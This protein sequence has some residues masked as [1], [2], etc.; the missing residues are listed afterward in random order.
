[1]T[2]L[3][4]AY[5]GAQ[6]HDGN[7]L[8]NAH[9]LVVNSDNS[10]RIAPAQ[11]LPDGCPVHRFDGGIITPAFVDLQVN[12]GGGVMFN[13]DPSVTT[14]Q[15]IACAHAASGTRALL[16]TLITDTPQKTRAAI[17]AVEQAIAEKVDGI[18]GIHLEGPHLSISRKGAHDP[19]LIRTMTHTDLAVICDA[20]GRLPNVMVTVAPENVSTRQIAQMTAAGVTVSLGH[21]NAD[22]AACHAAFDAGA[23]CVTHLFNAMS[24]L[25]SRAPGLVGATLSRDDI[26]AGLIA[27]AIHVHPDTIRIA[28]AAKPRSDKIFLVTDAMATA[29]SH[30]SRFTLNGRD[31]FRDNGRLTLADGTLA[32]A[33]LDMPRALSI[34]TGDVGDK[35]AKAIAR[36][37]STPA[38]VLRDPMGAGT[39]TGTSGTFLYFANGLQGGQPQQF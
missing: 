7:V 38:A 39:L 12:G 2:T 21:T 28:L 24:Q 31:V 34:M 23:R 15:T 30:I 29:G 3:Q 19:S 20:A 32:G 33:D 17:A 1:M 26:F 9:A 16:A 4:K 10:L 14:L 13:D 37:T 18:I 27:D 22:S 8:H 11:S 5:V 35:P 25:Q 36:A 6:I